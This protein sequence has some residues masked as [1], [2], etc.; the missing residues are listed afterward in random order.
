VQRWLAQIVNPLLTSGATVVGVDHV[1]KNGDNRGYARGASA[2]KARSRLVFDFDKQE[3][4][5]RTTLGE[6]LVALVK[7]SD[8]ALIPKERVIVL[9]GHPETE[10]FVF[11]V[12]ER[13]PVVKVDRRRDDARSVVDK[14]V[15]ILEKLDPGTQVSANKLAI[16]IG[17]KRANTLD[18]LKEAGTTPG[19]RLNQH[20]EEAGKKVYVRYSLR[21]DDGLRLP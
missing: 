16:D 19:G 6:V 18:A 5:G 21:T 20:T 13:D 2:K 3:D 14:A 15:T 17:G 11:R 8:A 9:G 12:S 7:N 10:Q 4:F 1:P